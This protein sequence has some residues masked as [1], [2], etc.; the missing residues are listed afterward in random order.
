MNYA[1]MGR[2]E[3]GAEEGGCNEHHNCFVKRLD[4]GVE[5]A[6]ACFHMQDL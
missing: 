3:G 5:A 2:L 6:T 1:L 4:E